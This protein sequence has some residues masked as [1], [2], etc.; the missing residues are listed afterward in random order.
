MA[1]AA[2]VSLYYLN[3]KCSGG[4]L[5]GTDYIAEELLPQSLHQI[6]CSQMRIAHQCLEKSPA[7]AGPFD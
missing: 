5:E 1:I 2:G 3:M 4:K 6:L 7:G